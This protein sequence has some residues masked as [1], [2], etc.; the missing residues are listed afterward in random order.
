M[1]DQVNLFGRPGASDWANNAFVQLDPRAVPNTQMGKAVAGLPQAWETPIE[2]PATVSQTRRIPGQSLGPAGTGDTTPGSPAESAVDAT[3]V[4]AGPTPIAP[5]GM[6]MS[7][8]ANT[9][10]ARQQQA[11]TIQGYIDQ[12]NSAVA[13][14]GTFDEVRERFLRDPDAFTID[15]TG[16]LDKSPE[17]GKRWNFGEMTS[18]N[19]LVVHHT[20]GRGGT[21]GV[22][23]TFT[24]RN[25]PAHFVIDREGQITQVLGLNQRGQH[26]KNAQDGSGITNANSWGVEVIAKDDADVLPVQA[27]ATVR[28]TKYLQQYGLQ[29]SRIVGHGAINSHKQATE[30]QTIAQLLREING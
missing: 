26:T 20:A 14:P 16:I 28:L 15:A 22:I 12:R 29:S 2:P 7:A 10:P 9:E 27:E 30:G 4:L 18:P 19:A 5:K 11:R 21:E 3:A 13:P 24:E 25:F 8:Y 1:V 6:L 17:V 23:Q